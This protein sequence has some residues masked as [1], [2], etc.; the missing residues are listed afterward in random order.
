M[1]SKK[2]KV[3]GLLMFSMV[4]ACTPSL[5]EVGSGY[6]VSPALASLLEEGDIYFLIM[7]DGKWIASR[8]GNLEDENV[9]AILVNIREKKIM[10]RAAPGDEI[11]IARN[12]GVDILKQGEWSCA[13]G[14]SRKEVGNSI[15]SSAFAEG[16]FNFS[17]DQKSLLKASQSSGL[18]AMAEH[19]QQAKLTEIQKRKE[20]EIAAHEKAE[21]D[22]M[23][24]DRLAEQGNADVKFQRGLFYL[25]QDRYNVE[26]EKWFEKAAALGHADALYK[27]ASFQ[28]DHYQNKVEAEHLIRKAAQAGSIEARV[29]LDAI[30]ADRKRIAIHEKQIAAKQANEQ[31]QIAAFQKSVASVVLRS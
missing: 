21:Q 12:S 14:T 23:A 11:G 30:L 25:G 19:D 2:S 31:R 8:T 16:I 26:A 20:A 4:C 28:N 27:L 7:V 17:V 22:R 15:C 18:I 5:A 9:A 6:S 24:Q 3:M 29:A 1:N 10:L 13:R